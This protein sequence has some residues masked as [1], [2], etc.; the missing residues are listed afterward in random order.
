M[1]HLACICTLL[2]SS[3]YT[4]EALRMGTSRMRLLSVMS[5]TR[6]PSLKEKVADTL[7]SGVFQIKVW[8]MAYA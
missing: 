7:I 3:A 5:L 1:L 4:G 6:E 2:L 8:H